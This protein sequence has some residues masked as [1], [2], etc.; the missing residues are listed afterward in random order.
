M[1]P[2]KDNSVHFAGV[3]MNMAAKSSMNSWKTAF[4]SSEIQ[5]NYYSSLIDFLETKSIASD[6][7]FVLKFLSVLSDGEKEDYRKDAKER[8]YKPPSIATAH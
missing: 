4:K 6:P 7:E 3:S 8:G 2:D 5:A 1:N